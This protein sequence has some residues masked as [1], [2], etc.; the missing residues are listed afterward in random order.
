MEKMDLGDRMK[1]YE[2]RET[3]RRVMPG[4]PIC[5]RID[6]RA[7]H[8]FTRGLARP[9]DERLTECMVET[10]RFLVQETGAVIGYTQS[11]EIT[12][13]FYTQEPGS[14]HFFGGKIQKMVSVLASAATC[15]FAKQMQDKLPEKADSL[16][17]FDCRVW[18]VPTLEEAC[19]V[20]VWR[21]LDA[22]R[23]QHSNGGFCGLQPPPTPREEPISYAGVVVPKGN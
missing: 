5:A 6:G 8:T 1:M 20:L 13:L 18:G 7:F 10:A 4:L 23:K 12:L 21:E 11:D 19:N 14:Q 22:T 9:Y 16:V 2:G 3:G 17:M 15:Q